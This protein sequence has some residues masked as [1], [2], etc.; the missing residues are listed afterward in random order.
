MRRHDARPC[1]PDVF[2]SL[3]LVSASVCREA[4]AR[5]RRALLI[6]RNFFVAILVKID[7]VEAGTTVRRCR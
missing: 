5:L 2:R 4:F 7:R 3:F 1:R 6:M